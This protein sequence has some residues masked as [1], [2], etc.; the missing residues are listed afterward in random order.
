MLR[1]IF[2]FRAR[3]YT[4]YIISA[5]GCTLISHWPHSCITTAI[6]RSGHAHITFTRLDNQQI[7]YWKYASLRHFGWNNRASYMAFFAFF[8][9]LAPSLSLKFD[10]TNEFQMPEGLTVER[11]TFPRFLACFFANYSS[12]RGN[13]VYMNLNNIQRIQ[14]N[15]IKLDRHK[16]RYNTKLQ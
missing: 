1:Y 5:L 13:A 4:K 15:G 10:I 9:D 3:P 16:S 2:C 12:R 7:I 11:M 8:E 14:G 6:V